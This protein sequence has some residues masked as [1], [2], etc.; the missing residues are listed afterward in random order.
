M[1]ELGTGVSCYPK[2]EGTKEY[3]HFVM[4]MAPKVP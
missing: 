2:Q 4:T 1:I 3:L